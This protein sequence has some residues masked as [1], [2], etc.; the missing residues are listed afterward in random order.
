[1]HFYTVFNKDGKEH[2][3]SYDVALKIVSE[4][5]QAESNISETKKIKCKLCGCDTDHSVLQ[6]CDVCYDK[7]DTQRQ[8]KEYLKRMKK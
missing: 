3:M 2:K 6:V 8:L 4:K 7:F 5:K 1:M